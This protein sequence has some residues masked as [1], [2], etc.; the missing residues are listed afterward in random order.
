MIANSCRR[1]T[2]GESIPFG[3]DRLVID[4]SNTAQ[5]V[6]FNPFKPSGVK[7]LHFTVFR[8]IVV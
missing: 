7:W 8:A 5:H 1:C 6:C 2:A 3:G 4:I